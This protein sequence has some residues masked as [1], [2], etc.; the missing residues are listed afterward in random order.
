VIIIPN[1]VIMQRDIVNW[2]ASGASIRL[3]IPIGISY[4]APPAKAKALCLEAAAACDGVL[5]TPEPVCILRSFGDSSVNL[6]LR[7]WLSDARERR[8]IDDWITDHVKTLFDANGIEI[9]Y[10][11]RDLYIK[12]MPEGRSLSGNT[13]AGAN[14]GTPPISDD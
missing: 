13:R 12:S 9:P 4:D 5:K 6:E 3:R 1:S 14:G 8:A 11:K 7:V 2:T 10:P